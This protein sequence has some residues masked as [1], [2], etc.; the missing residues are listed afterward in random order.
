[1]IQ[2]LR[3]VIA[4][5]TYRRD[6]ADLAREMSSHLAL[7]E[8]DYRR[9]G[10]TP[11][12]A[13]LAARRAMGSV[14]LAKDLH[15]D[16]RSFVW[17]DDLRRDLRHAVRNLRRSPGFTLT[18]VLALGLGIG[19]NAAFFT[20]L[21][22][23]CLRGLPVES[24]ERVMW[25]ST[26]NAQNRSGG[27]SY[28]EFGELRARTTTF[29]Q[30]AAY[31]NTIAAV[32]DNRQ[33][34]AR[35][36][37]AF[38]SAGAFELIGV[39][40]VVGRTFRPDEDRPGGSAVVILGAEIWSSRYGSDPAI[41]GQSITVNGL[42]STVIGVMPRGFMFPA[43]ADLWRPMADLAL[44]VRE[45]RA[46]RRLSVFARLQ[47]GA[48]E[49]QARSDMLGIGAAWAREF[50]A[51]NRDI[52]LH[53]VPIN[54][55][56]NPDW[57]HPGWLSFI[58]AGTLVL[59][60]ACANV[61]NLLLMRAATRGREIAIRTSIG[62]TRGRVVRQLLVESAALAA[63][64]GAFGIFVAWSATRALEGMAPPEFLPY[65][66]AFTID[67]RVLAVLSAVCLGSVFV[68]G[69]PSALHV[70]KV[71]LRDT[72]T[73][74]GSTTIAARPARRWIAVLLAAEFAMTLVLNAMAVGSIRSSIE[75]RRREFR[76]DP[77][78]LTT[79]WLTLPADA[80][81]TADVRHAFFDRLDEAVGT[82][83]ALES[84]AY[85]STL[86][87][88]G[89]SQQPLTVSG[90]S[91][92]EAPPMVSVVNA[93]E[94]Y[95]EIFR[96]PMVR[97]RAF[98]AA[99]GHPGSEAA[100]VNERF[101]RMFLTD[102]EPIGAR[103]RLGSEETPWLQ[104]V[105][106][107]TTVRQQQMPSPEPDPVVFLPFRASNPGTT[108]IIVR[109]ARDPAAAVSLL[110]RAVADI[111]PNLPLYRVMSLDQAVKNAV[112]NGTLSDMLVKSIAVV[113]LLLAL[114]GLYAVT[115]H[116]V[117]WWSR[118]LGLRVALGARGRAI[119][120]LVLR[121]MLVQLSAGFALGL[122]AVLGYDRLFNSGTDN[123]LA[124][125]GALA[126]TMLAIVIVA[127]VACL[128]PIRRAARVDPLVALR[129]E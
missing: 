37:G 65:W 126:L 15:R 7:L 86:P 101:V 33:P 6:E 67:G 8:D 84:I 119:A 21:N 114:V 3:R 58:T 82:S 70:S 76:I 121:R 111:D 95:F 97:G 125:P 12:D 74:N 108:A 35:V 105:G 1:M 103:I 14:A 10:M 120:W 53:T 89:G 28:A 50:S 124:E 93:S 31:T 38:I 87:Y 100:V 46:E 29:E 98:T 40:P 27:L 79:M 69:L 51:T 127:L 77:A 112:W 41:V 4:S 11:D 52:Q 55:A 26:R 2:L 85:A 13:R 128:V 16:A 90:R 44:A 22:A 66:M 47:D 9:R 122:V 94:R 75:T 25:L 18:A 107:A 99:D 24:P 102:Q 56:L 63:C 43:N 39:R 20:I 91:L 113:A 32:G 19:V 129:A 61:A 59:L 30:I 42:P 72:L 62:A 110:R 104:I 118:E 73:E 81:R 17:L 54:E 123:R 71:D 34:P 23:I 109:T 68:C 117:A 80:Y 64:A 115:S 88:G 45:S 49:D 60:V 116:T 36:L 106:V 48:T 5:F 83:P 92:G 96:V 57:T 78:S